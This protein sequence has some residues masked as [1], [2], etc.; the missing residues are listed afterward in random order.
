MHIHK[1][2]EHCSF[3]T[4]SINKPIQSTSLVVFLG[5]KEIIYHK[6][7]KKI[8]KNQRPNKVNYKSWEKQIDNRYGFLSFTNRFYIYP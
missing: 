1:E 2:K 7:D 4:F 3:I 8:R 5:G 6:K